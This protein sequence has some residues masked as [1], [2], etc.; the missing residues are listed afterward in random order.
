MNFQF[1][2]KYIANII[3]G[4][5]IIF[6]LP[7]VFIP[8]SSAWFYIFYL[9]CGLTDM[10]D[11]AIARRTG[12]V[13]KFGA[14]LDTV[15]DFVF[16]VVSLYQLLPSMHITAW[17]W[18]WSSVIAVI[19]ICNIIWGYVIEKHFISLHTMMNKVTG[20]LLFLFPLTISFVD[21]K[22]TAIIVCAIATF[23]AIQ[24]GVY[25]VAARK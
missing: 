18:V 15:A 13:S 8:L 25:A 14:T 12:A 10:I 21:P 19:K 16:V 22:Y 7:L 5:R 17:L 1:M 24:E 20:L 23:S 9:F 4:S 3:T 6:S 11:G 2:K